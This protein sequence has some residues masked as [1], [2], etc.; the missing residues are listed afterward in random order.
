MKLVLVGL[1]LAA[2][3][4]ISL[5]G[6]PAKADSLVDPTSQLAKV[7]AKLDSAADRKDIDGCMA[8]LSPNFMLLNLDGKVEDSTAQREHLLSVFAQFNQLE[9][10]TRIDNCQYTDKTA[11]VEITQHVKAT[12]PADDGAKPV[13]MEGDINARELWTKDSAGWKIDLVQSLGGGQLTPDPSGG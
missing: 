2:T 7:Y 13:V 4:G 10:T 1:T 12:L 8:S 6:L 11:T 3:L 5:P 9:V